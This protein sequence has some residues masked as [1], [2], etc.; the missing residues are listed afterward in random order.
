MANKTVDQKVGEEERREDATKSMET[1]SGREELEELAQQTI[2]DIRT[3]AD[4]VATEGTSLLE[5][6]LGNLQA[7]PDEVAQAKA[8]LDVVN[9]EIGQLAAVRQDEVRE[10]VA[11]AEGVEP[12]GRAGFLSE[13]E[14]N[15]E[16]AHTVDDV[17]SVLKEVL[18][19]QKDRGD[20]RLLFDNFRFAPMDGSEKSLDIEDFFEEQIRSLDGALEE[21][22]FKDGS[23]D[24]IKRDAKTMIEELVLPRLEGEEDPELLTTMNKIQ[25]KV[26]VQD[27]DMKSLVD[28]LNS[29]RRLSKGREKVFDKFVFKDS[30]KKKD[31]LLDT[32]DAIRLLDTEPG[33]LEKIDVINTGGL[34]QSLGLFGTSGAS[35]I[36]EQYGRF[37]DLRAMPLRSLELVKD[38]EY[39]HIKSSAVEAG[40]VALI[41]EERLKEIR[42]FVGEDLEELK[43]EQ[44]SEYY[45]RIESLPP[46]QKEFCRR[47]YQEGRF[48]GDFSAIGSN[49][50]FELIKDDVTFSK[51][52]ECYSRGL[53]KSFYQIGELEKIPSLN[54]EDIVMVAEM[55]EG[56]SVSR[57]LLGEARK[58]TQRDFSAYREMRDKFGV[59]LPEDKTGIVRYLNG[60][61]AIPV[62]DLDT[63]YRWQE[64]RKNSYNGISGLFASLEEALAHRGELSELT[65]FYRNNPNADAFVLNFAVRDGTDLSIIV[66]SIKVF[67]TSPEQQKAVDIFLKFY[68]SPS[69]EMKNMALE[70]TLQ[71]VSGDSSM[72]IEERYKQ[73][74]DIFIKNNIPFVGKQAKTCAVLHPRIEV[75][76]NSSPELRALHSENARRLLLFKDL[77]RANFNSLNS[78]L[79]QYLTVFQGGQKVLDKYE[80]G[81]QL[82]GEEEEELK[83]FFGKVNALSEN[84]RKTDK[85]YKFDLSGVSLGENLQALKHNFGVREGQTVTGRFEE[86]FLKRIGIGS[87]SEALTYYD[88]L[89][90]STDTRNKEFAAT[91]QIS[92]SGE[93]LI[94]GVSADFFGSNL[95]RGFY[96]PEFIGAETVL[97]KD[98]AK[99][100][101][102]TPW[103][104][105]VVKVGSL[106]IEEVAESSLAAGYGDFIVVIRDLGQFHK[107]ANGQPLVGDKDKLE[108]FKTE[109]LEENHYGI[110]TGFGSTEVSALIVRDNILNDKKRLDSL[111][112]SIAKKG[113]YIPICNK[114]GKVVFTPAEFE[115]YKRFANRPDK[116]QGGKIEVTSLS[117]TRERLEGVLGN[118]EH[119]PKDILNL[120][121]EDF[122]DSLDSDVGV[123][124][125]YSLR[126]H[127]LMMMEQ[128]RKY[129]SDN[130]NIGDKKF[131]EVILALHD[132][133]KPWAVSEDVAEKQHEYTKKIIIPVLTQLRYSPEEIKLAVSLIDGDP[134]G[135][136]LSSGGG[137]I[138]ESAKEILEMAE[139]SGVPLDKFWQM[140]LIFYQSDAGSYTEDAGGLNSLDSQF[141]FGPDKHTMDFSEANKEKIR[142]LE[143]EV[144][145]LSSRK[146]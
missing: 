34:D 141:S 26:A 145:F 54:E 14:T 105:D 49:V 9:G 29:Y 137:R 13:V 76:N 84:T 106:T 25:E 46:D 96:S 39:F 33:L 16:E 10:V 22:G 18:R 65:E 74:E 12:F 91:G 102:F 81:G 55:G 120:L 42:E 21:P 94:K 52:K 15:L 11:E 144:N 37:A 35:G 125:G 99:K 118:L 142:V 80:V 111:K 2:D 72:T 59:A 112:F 47:V 51:I 109:G 97:A 24:E 17:L 71:L 1:P 50:F 107:T 7:E 131:F 126:E 136:Y 63:F 98:L 66:R 73:V 4:G 6:S 60:I 3:R 103:D 134:I 92:L 83:R 67:Q 43:A 44:V 89:R 75:Q 87:F 95:D 48:E 90:K 133:G 68:S 88:D 114:E 104:T 85:F 143:E 128:F 121:E 64:Q 28:F 19:S 77:L 100:S 117:F 62:E 23:I 115:K 123:W 127:T 78:N 27:Y 70:L 38:N 86:A 58:L 20:L 56:L 32:K 61:K 53:I 124:E 101:D 57:A 31:S 146:Q 8:A 138:T 41:T 113:F 140:L 108:L 36:S 40:A 135:H 129:F 110:R 132:I 79:E 69:S 119:S 139:G 45:K 5:S 82:T 116:Y 122:K 93:D 130:A 30:L